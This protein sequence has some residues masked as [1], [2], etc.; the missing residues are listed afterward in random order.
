VSAHFLEALASNELGPEEALSEIRR[1]FDEGNAGEEVYSALVAGVWQ[2]LTARKFGT[3]SR[4][5]HDLF[6]QVS[7]LY[8][9]HE[10][11]DLAE[12]MRVLSDLAMASTRFGET[13]G[14]TAL[15]SR[16]Y[17]LDILT[18]VIELGGEG[19]KRE[20]VRELT[21]VGEA[22]LSRIL[23]TLESAGLLTRKRVGKEVTLGITA[24]GRAAATGKRVPPRDPDPSPDDAI[25][26]DFEHL[27]IHPDFWRQ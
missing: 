14:K 26:P 22:N 9:A 13:N 24:E 15:L 4:A 18:A 2:S 27:E 19:A 12:R 8:R 5:W 10:R 6:R 21:G 7:S 3:E 16:A 1:F 11:L 17:V 25:R 20:K 23:G